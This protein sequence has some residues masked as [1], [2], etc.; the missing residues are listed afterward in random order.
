MPGEQLFS[1]AEVTEIVKRA[2]ELQESGRQA[3]EY[4]PGVTRTELTRIAGEI[5]IEVAFLEQAIR[6]RLEPRQERKGFWRSLWPQPVERVVDGELD[7][8]DYDILTEHLPTRATNAPPSQVGRTLTAK[9]MT[10][11]TMADVAVTARNGRT[12]IKVSPLPILPLVFGGQAIL[13][14]AGIA[15]GIMGDKGPL[16]MAL[17][18]GIGGLLSGLGLVIGGLRHATKSSQVIATKLETQIM[19]EQRAKVAARSA[20]SDQEQ[21]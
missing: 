5:G 7:P 21:P 8:E 9:V 19:E 17:A 12:R 18:V 16:V 11:L 1:E 14:G 10:G 2:V 4:V 3:Q 15:G 13:V 6:E 20:E